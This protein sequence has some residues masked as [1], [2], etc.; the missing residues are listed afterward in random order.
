MPHKKYQQ[1]PVVKYPW[2]YG[3]AGG[4]F[5]C[6]I[7]HPLDLAKV[8]LQTISL[9]KPSLFFMMQRI[10]K[11]EGIT[12]L[13]SG[14]SASILRQCTYTT[15]RFGCYDFI[16]EN[17]IPKKEINNTIYLLPCSM[18]SGAIGGFVGN[19]ADV[20]NIRMQN[21]SA[22]EPHLRRNYKHGIDGLCRILKDEGVKK[23]F[24]GLTPNLVR[25]VLMTASQVVTYDVFKNYLVTTL[26]FDPSK[27]ATHFSASLMAG[28]VATTVCSPADVI[29]TRIMNAHQHH[30]SAFNVL[31]NS[32]KNEGVQFMFRGWVPSFVRLGPNTILIFLAVEQLRSYRVGMSH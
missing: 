16:K 30:E 20:V 27:K 3:G 11:T 26:D 12:G 10:L 18:L 1:N 17:F 13:Y 21:D 5:A 8:R 4:V 14:L 2:W 29:K 19:P 32:I 24:T 6:I 28:L 7:T 31:K 15:A 9:P 22:H 23:L 25:G